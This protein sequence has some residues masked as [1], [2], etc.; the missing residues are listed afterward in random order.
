MPKP[1]S[2]PSPKELNLFSRPGES[3]ESRKYIAER[4]ELLKI[5]AHDRWAFLQGRDVDGTPM[6]L[7]QDEADDD[8]PFKPFPSF[9]YLRFIT[10]EL[11]GPQQVSLIDKSRQMTVSTVCMLLLYHTTLF[12]RG[13]KC[14]VSKQTQELAE[15][16]LEDKIRGV[17]RRTPEWFQLA[18]PLSMTPKSV[19]RAERTGS[20]IVCVAQNAASRWFKGNTASIV[21]IDEAAVQE[22]LE[23]MLQAA[24][25][26]AKRI[27]AITTA[28]HGNPGAAL[29]YK[30]KTES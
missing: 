25:P 14:L 1:L 15:V 11:F 10:Q 19:A 13:R 4:R 20:E 8:H 26:M 28:F 22:F 5:W 7:T 27:W 3:V 6:I 21:L 30:L 2:R 9:D 17:H 18:M 24:T 29:F 12:K 16:L 23:D